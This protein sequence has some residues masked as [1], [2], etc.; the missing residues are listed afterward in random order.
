M[1]DNKDEE[2]K[3]IKIP[4]SEEYSDAIAEEHMRRMKQLAPQE[5]YTLDIDGKNITYKRRK[6]RTAE[7]AKL[8]VIR[9]ELADSLENNRKSYPLLEDKL[10]KQMAEYYLINSKT[11]KGMTKDEFDLTE[12]EEIKQILNACAFR[13]ER[14]IPSPAPLEK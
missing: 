8:E 2:I 7:R 13:T 9:Q 10:Y 14:P 4:L 3:E 5:E 12:F 1:S 11:G 6:I